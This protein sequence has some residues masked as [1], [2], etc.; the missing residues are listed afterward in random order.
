MVAMATINLTPDTVQVRFTASEKFWGLIRDIDVPRTQVS[1]A[2]VE[3]DALAAVT[4]MR[5]PGLGWPG[6]RKI[7]TWRGKGRTAVTVTAGQ[8]AVRIELTGAQWDRLLIGHDDPQAV[9]DQ[10][11]AR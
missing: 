1:E 8:P 3:T 4:G 2:V 7:G 5:A 11:T 9:V 10:L 6:R